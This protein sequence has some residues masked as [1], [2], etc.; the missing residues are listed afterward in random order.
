MNLRKDHYIFEGSVLRS[1]ISH[2]YTL[3][4]DI[5]YLLRWA[6]PSAFGFNPIKIY[7]KNI[8]TLTIINI[9]TF[10]NGSLGSRNDEERSELR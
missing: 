2:I 8:I 4:L 5:D 3:C 9:K 1:T 7:M 6:Y 10:N